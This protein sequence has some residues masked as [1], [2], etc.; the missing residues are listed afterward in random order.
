MIKSAAFAA[1]A[2]DYLVKLPDNIELVARIVTTR[3][4]I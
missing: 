2:N 3:A 4:P 1:G